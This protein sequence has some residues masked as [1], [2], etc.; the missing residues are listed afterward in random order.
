MLFTLITL[1]ALTCFIFS[2]IYLRKI[3]T[4]WWQHFRWFLLLTTLVEASGY[5]LYFVYGIKNHALF[6]AFLPVEYVFISWAMYKL[7]RPYYNCKPWIGLGL[8]IVLAIYLYES[9]VAKFNGYSTN[10]TIGASIFFT[11]IAGMYFYHF[12]KSE[13][14]EKLAAFAPFW[15]VAGIFIFY[16]CGTGINFFFNYLASV[17]TANPFNLKLTRYKIQ[18]ILNFILY[19]FWAYAFVCRYQQT[20]STRS[21]LL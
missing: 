12:M 9:T 2:F 13:H 7:S 11:I 17:N 10:S 8:A 3:E 1:I 16:F 21:S 5:C 4:G 18:I 6:N 19:A 20:I 15:I 14:Y